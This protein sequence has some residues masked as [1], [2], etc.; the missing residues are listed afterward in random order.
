MSQLTY[1]YESGVEINDIAALDIGEY[2]CTMDAM[3]FVE[4]HEE[5]GVVLGGLLLSLGGVIAAY[6]YVRNSR[7]FAKRDV[8]PA[9]LCVNATDRRTS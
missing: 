6:V 4:S 7:E 2:S 1:L 8:E 3:S 9:F 5:R